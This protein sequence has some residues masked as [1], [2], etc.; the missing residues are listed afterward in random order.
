M[1]QHFNLALEHLLSSNSAP[2]LDLEFLR[3]EE[4][5]V[6]ECQ[7]FLDAIVARDRKVQGIGSEQLGCK[8]GHKAPGQIKILDGRNQYMQRIF[9]ESIEFVEERTG[10]GARLNLTSSAR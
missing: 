5:A 7:N 10:V 1:V 6:I 4:Q 3:G 9:G 2:C 8:F